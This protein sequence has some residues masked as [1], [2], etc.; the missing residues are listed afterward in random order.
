MRS[1]I[2][3]LGA[4]LYTLLTGIV[5]QESV[6]RF[7]EDELAPP[8]ELNPRIN[9]SV[10]DAIMQ[11]MQLDA[12]QR[13]PSADRFKDAILG[14]PLGYVQR[15]SR[16]FVQAATAQA[17]MVGRM[18]PG[19]GIRPQRRALIVLLILVAS[20]LSLM[21]IF[22]EGPPDFPG[23]SESAAPALSISPT[24]AT[25]PPPTAKPAPTNPTLT[26]QPPTQVDALPDKWGLTVT[27]S[28]L[29]VRNLP[30]TN[31]LVIGAVYQGDLLTTDG[32]TEEVDG[33][34]WYLITTTDGMQGWV[35]GE[36]VDNPRDP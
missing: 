36:F 15:Q 5:P 21:F 16:S 14:R 12:L 9:S 6:Q 3:S 30:G 23:S 29:N 28:G 33:E 7:A 17:R 26:P 4:T 25:L 11:A 19:A 24:A 32:Y 34:V 35:S 20:L 27:V 31:S 2:Y 22:R 18:R 13:F 8:K 10:N 1:D